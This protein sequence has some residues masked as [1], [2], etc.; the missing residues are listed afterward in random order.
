MQSFCLT[1]KYHQVP[2]R[3]TWSG[4]NVDEPESLIRGGKQQTAVKAGIA[5]QN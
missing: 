2:D 5:A 1:I 4:N 3:T